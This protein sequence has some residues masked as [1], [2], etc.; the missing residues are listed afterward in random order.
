MA[1][2]FSQIIKGEQAGRDAMWKQEERDRARI[3]GDITLQ[4]QGMELIAAQQK[5]DDQQ[6]AQQAAT[7]LSPMLS[8]QQQ[9]AD[10][11][12][13]D[14]DWLLA[15]RQTVLSDPNFQGFRPEVQ[16]KVLEGLSTKA[17]VLAN[18][19]IKRNDMS[20]AR[21]ILDAFAMQSTAPTDTQTAMASGDIAGT[22]AG[23]GWT[24]N[25]D[26]KTATGP[27]GL[28]Q[29]LFTVLN[30]IAQAKGLGGP[31]ATWNLGVAAEQQAAAQA[32]V[33]S[34]EITNYRTTQQNAAIQTQQ[35]MMTAAMNPLAVLL[36]NGDVRL[37][38]IVYQAAYGGAPRIATAAD[39]ATPATPAQQ[40]AAMIPQPSQSAIPVAPASAY[41]NAPAAPNPN[42]LSP[43][44]LPRA[45]L[46]AG[47]N[48]MTSSTSLTPEAGLAFSYATPADAVRL[49]VRD[50]QAANKVAAELDLLATLIAAKGTPEARLEAGRIMRS[51]QM[52]RGD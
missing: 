15:Q 2:D 8:L 41:S 21:Q 52:F 27:G 13:S 32:A 6:A 19:Y 31:A 18:E 35:E 33:N 23:A 38:N 22:L 46:L 20:T 43:G 28:Q 10:L 11:G 42:T 29:P 24:L 37:G 48:T 14:L 1:I 39:A 36:P 25:D 9:A 45:Q 5:F 49:R 3:Q 34:A 30:T 50:P 47:L 16:Q 51:A 44:S 4:K 40:A 7:Y 12:K 26:G 17:T